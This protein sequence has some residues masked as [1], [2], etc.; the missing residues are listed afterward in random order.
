MDKYDEI[1]IE[2]FMASV[3]TPMRRVGLLKGKVRIRKDFDMSLPEEILSEFEGN[4]HDD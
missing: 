1:S 4:G 2:K 3:E